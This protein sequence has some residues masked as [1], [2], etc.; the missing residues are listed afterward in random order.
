MS[1]ESIL[2]TKRVLL[3]KKIREIMSDGKARTT[4]E[5]V[6]MLKNSGNRKIQFTPKQV[7]M[8]MKNPDFIKVGETLDFYREHKV[9]T[10]KLRE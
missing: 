3:K 2:K 9:P 6:D 8:L 7:G 4:A 5:I 1:W 10:Y